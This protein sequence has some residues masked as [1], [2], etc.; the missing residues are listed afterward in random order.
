MDMISSL[1]ERKE[2]KQLSLFSRSQAI[3]VIA[4][5]GAA[6][7][8]LVQLFDPTVG[9]KPETWNYH[10]L[11]S[12]GLFQGVFALLLCAGMIIWMPSEST[13]GYE[14]AAQSQGGD[15]IGAPAGVIW[16]DD[17]LDEEGNT[18]GNQVAVSDKPAE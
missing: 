8:V 18:K 11:A 9:E 16:D 1:Q 13:Q 5:L 17:D 2:D 12:D 7:V 15:V 6:A 4:T 10:F 14:Y 3:M